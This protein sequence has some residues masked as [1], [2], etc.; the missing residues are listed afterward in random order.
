MKRFCDL[1]LLLAA[2]TV[3][4]LPIAVVTILV[5]LTS[6]GPVLYWSDRI[7][8]Y[9]RIFR[10]PKFRTMRIDTPEVAS[11]LLVDAD[12]WLTPIG[13]F[14]RRS[15]L[16]E[17]PQLWSI[18]TGEMSFVGPR[19]ALHN[20]HDLIALRT[21]KGV[22]SLT[23]GL[24]GWAQINGRDES[25]IPEK[26]AMDEY[27]L[28]H[29]SIWF[30]I[31]ILYLTALQVVRRRGTSVPTELAGVDQSDLVPAEAYL[32]SGDSLVK[33]NDF[34]RAMIA[35]TRATELAPMNSAAYV[36]RAAVWLAKGDHQKADSDFA[37]AAQLASGLP[38]PAAEHHCAHGSQRQA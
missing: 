30:D 1:I 3:F 7:G 23:P 15:S 28:D 17:L 20:Q 16:D 19:P 11:H 18:L 13:S 32:A 29:R 9:N 27:Y 8:R 14:L 25:P 26:V 36:K 38:I 33:V 37:T 34:E 5:R 35:F 21:Y 2:A 12:K 4:A 10:M 22:H 6:P 24:T 31:K